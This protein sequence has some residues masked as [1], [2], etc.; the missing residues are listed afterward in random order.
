M[1]AYTH[2]KNSDFHPNF[3]Y[4]GFQTSDLS[5]IKYTDWS[6]GQLNQIQLELDQSST[7][8]FKLGVF[9]VGQVYDCLQAQLSFSIGLMQSPFLSLKL[10]S[11]LC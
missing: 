3:L 6:L 4:L 5:W 8:I 9:M 1:H 2:T 10:L 7:S 11:C